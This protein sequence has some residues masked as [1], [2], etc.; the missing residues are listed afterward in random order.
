MVRRFALP[1]LL[2]MSMPALAQAPLQAVSD[3]DLARYA[4]TWHEIAN[5]DDVRWGGSGFPTPDRH[6]SAPI[7]AKSWHH[8]LVVTLPPLAISVFATAP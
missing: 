5:S 1:L 4:G 2:M 6:D 3:L 7:P 8:S